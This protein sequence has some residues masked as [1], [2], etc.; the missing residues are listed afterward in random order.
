MKKANKLAPQ[1]PAAKKPTPK[2]TAA[3]KPIAKKPA[4]KK[5]SAKPKR[6]AAEQGDFAQVLDRI[7]SDQG[8][9]IERMH[10]LAQLV[11]RLMGIVDRLLKAE[12]GGED[13]HEIIRQPPV[14]DEVARMAQWLCLKCEAL[15]PGEDLFDH[16]APG[17]P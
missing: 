5:S 3:N 17:E 12:E 2:K 9:I 10:Q 7:A 4:A 1:K 15:F 13:T 14:T 11:E 8:R 6:K 16:N